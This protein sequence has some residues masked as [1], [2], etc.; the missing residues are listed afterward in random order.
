MLKIVI[1]NV[2]TKMELKVQVKMTF[3]KINENIVLFYVI[4]FS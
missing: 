2:S 3:I 1:T 4:N